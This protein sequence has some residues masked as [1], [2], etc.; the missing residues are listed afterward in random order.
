[1]YFVATPSFPGPRAAAVPETELAFLRLA[2][3]ST[4]VA[5]RLAA[6]DFDFSTSPCA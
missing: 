3:A 6:A 5:V 1:M 2:A 4:R